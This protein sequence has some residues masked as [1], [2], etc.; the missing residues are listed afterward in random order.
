MIDLRLQVIRLGLEFICEL[1]Q[2][3]GFVLADL[4]DLRRS[5]FADALIFRREM[6]EAFALENMGL[7]REVIAHAVG[8]VLIVIANRVGPIVEMISARF[9]FFDKLL[10][11]GFLRLFLRTRLV[12]DRV[13]GLHDG[14]YDS[15]LFG[16][17]F[18]Q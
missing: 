12:N 17:E 4:L 18:F 16:Q 2:L 13:L 3:Q 6:M 11:L 14:F 15:G 10:D 7:V 8:L 5:Q 1:F 9:I